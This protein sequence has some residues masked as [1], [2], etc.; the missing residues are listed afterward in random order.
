MINQKNLTT[1]SSW[2]DEHTDTV[3]GIAEHKLSAPTS[4]LGNY[5]FS[6][7]LKQSVRMILLVIVLQGFCAGLH[8]QPISFCIRTDKLL[9]FKTFSRLSRIWDGCLIITT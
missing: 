3:L 6:H 9:H 4:A 5:T 7:S 8:P 1:S 2:T